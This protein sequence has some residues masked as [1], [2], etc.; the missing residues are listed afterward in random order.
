MHF[1]DVPSLASKLAQSEYVCKS[2]ESTEIFY[3]C[4][5]HALSNPACSRGVRGWEGEAWF[6]HLSVL[7]SSNLFW[8]HQLLAAH[9]TAQQSQAWQKSNK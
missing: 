4:S 9:P 6:L 8:V 5:A 2:E 7:K 1:T 3:F